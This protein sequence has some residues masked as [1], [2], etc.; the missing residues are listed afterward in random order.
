M[1]LYNWIFQTEKFVG[2][3]IYTNNKTQIYK[4]TR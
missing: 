4:N 1:A 3:K 2:W